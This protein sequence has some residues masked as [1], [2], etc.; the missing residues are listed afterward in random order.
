MFLHL[1]TLPHHTAANSHVGKS[2]IVPRLSLIMLSTGIKVP[3][4]LSIATSLAAATPIQSLAIRQDVLP[5]PDCDQPGAVYRD[6]CWSIKEVDF[7]LANPVTG[8]TI[9]T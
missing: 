6:V 4:L 1:L 2:T 5:A 9:S 8:T 3:L 7:Y